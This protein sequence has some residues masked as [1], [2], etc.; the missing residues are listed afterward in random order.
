MATIPIQEI[1]A[2]D[3]GLSYIVTVQDRDGV[4]DLSNATLIEFHFQKPDGSML[5]VPASLV[6]DGVDGR[7][8]YKTDTSDFDQTGPWR[9]QV[10]VEIG[11]DRKWS[12]ITKFKVYPNLPLQI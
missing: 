7:V 4:V 5:V 12:N 11:P 9:H 3:R 2:N 10:Y 1:H 8:S 6:T